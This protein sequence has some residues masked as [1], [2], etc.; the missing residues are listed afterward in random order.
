M[1]VERHVSGTGSLPEFN[2]AA[3]ELTFNPV[4]VAG[5]L[6]A[7]EDEN[8]TILNVDL[9]RH[10]LGVGKGRDDGS[11]AQCDDQRSNPSHATDLPVENPPSPAKGP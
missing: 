3:R 9:L 5:P 11:A 4:F 8:A 2:R 6:L 10:G 1:E 7:D